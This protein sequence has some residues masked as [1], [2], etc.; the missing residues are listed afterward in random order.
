MRV[1]R[2]FRAADAHHDLT[3]R[4]GILS[5]SL[6]LHAGAPRTGLRRNRGAQV[7]HRFRGSLAR[8]LRSRPVWRHA[9][10]EHIMSS[11]MIHAKSAE[12]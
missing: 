3:Y 4:D 12:A 8:C 7:I 6:V 9:P 2:A 10:E 5:L 11:M 1:S